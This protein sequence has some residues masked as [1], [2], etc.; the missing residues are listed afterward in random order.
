MSFS[1]LCESC[2]TD[3]GETS[4]GGILEKA[5]DCERKFGMK[6]IAIISPGILPVPATKGGA[7][8]SL[9][10]FLAE[11]NEKVEGVK[12]DLFSISAGEPNTKIYKNTAVYE[13]KKS[14]FTAL[15][16]KIADKIYRTLPGDVSA[17]RF[18]DKTIISVVKKVLATAQY[19][20]DAIVVENQMSLAVKV[21]ESGLAG[22]CPVFF[23][24]HNDVDIYR[25]PYYCRELA[26][27]GVTFICVSEYIKNSV[28]KWAPDANIKVLYNGTDTNI[29]D[30]ELNKNRDMV[31]EEL[32]IAP[33]ETVFLY[34]GRI[35][36]QKGVSEL[37]DA[38][39]AF[40]KKNK[41]ASSRLLIVGLGDIPT[42][43]E[44]HIIEKCTKVGDNILYHKK[45]DAKRMAEIVA[46]A[47]V[48][49][50][51]TMDEEPFGMV[52]IEAMAMGKPV[53]ATE[54]G[55]LCELLTG[56][57]AVLVP[58]D[59]NLIGGL[60]EGFRALMDAHLREKLGKGSVNL[61]VEKGE[62]HKDSFYRNFCELLGII[63]ECKAL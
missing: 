57:N 21:I 24:M 59:E 30:Y 36:R 38:Y 48:V 1:I 27:K 26:A 20:Y 12:F 11:E 31:R 47:D 23:H 4:R 40:L 43:Y 56:D 52:A 61:F 46:C 41:G 32:G 54:S 13:V 25:S 50:I 51:P 19:R 39:E 58:K 2:I 42:K 16:D 9:L 5:Y 17:K 18:F 10:T 49:T 28:Q 14:A 15:S 44:K 22:D 55:A 29:F 34:S 63:H 6:H 33:E 45:V 62:W 53:I 37:I 7:V 35:I 60:S 8:E 3:S